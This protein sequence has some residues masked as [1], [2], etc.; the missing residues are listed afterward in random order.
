MDLYQEILKGTDLLYQNCEIEG[1]AWFEK[2]QNR[3]HEEL[4][5]KWQA[6]YG[7][8]AEAKEMMLFLVQSMAEACNQKDILALA[9]TLR[10]E[11]LEYIK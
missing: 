4:I 5:A 8:S 3:I 10:Y 6:K 11:V 9:D 2:Q 1:Y 7:A